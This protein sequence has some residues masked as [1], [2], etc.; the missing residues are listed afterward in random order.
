MRV[1]IFANYS[2]VFKSLNYNLDGAL[3]LDYGRMGQSLSD[4]F[5]NNSDFESATGIGFGLRVMVPT[6][7]KS[8]NIDIVWGED[9]KSG[10]GELRFTRNPTWHLY[11]DL[12]Y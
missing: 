10:K 1:P 7:E 4:L 5:N 11:V 6:L 2:D 3:I 12:H 9:P 8:A